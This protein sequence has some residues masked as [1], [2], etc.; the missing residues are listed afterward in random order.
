M[1]TLKNVFLYLLLFGLFCLGCY[2]FYTGVSV[3]LQQL[4]QTHAAQAQTQSVP[5]TW[6]VNDWKEDSDS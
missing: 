6:A 2:G 5:H 1:T 4:Q 3:I